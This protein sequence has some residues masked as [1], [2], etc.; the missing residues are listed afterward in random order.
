MM[1]DGDVM[2]EQR[3]VFQKRRYGT[4]ENVETVKGLKKGM[5]KRQEKI[6]QK[7]IN[8]LSPTQPHWVRKITPSLLEC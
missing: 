7:Q 4:N 6:K 3:R 1:R 8:A 2:G 5:E